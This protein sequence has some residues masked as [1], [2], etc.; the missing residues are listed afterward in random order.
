MSETESLSS[1]IRLETR[2][3]LRSPGRL[4]GARRITAVPRA[5]GSRGPPRGRV[6]GAVDASSNEEKRPALRDDPIERVLSLPPSSIELLSSSGFLRGVDRPRIQT[7]YVGEGLK[8]LLKEGG[9][10]LIFS[11]GPPDSTHM[12]GLRLA[13]D[14]GLPWVADFRDP[15]FNLHMKKPP[16][17]LH[18]VLHRRMEAMVLA[19]AEPVTV[20]EGWRRFLEE[21]RGLPVHLIRNCFDPTDF[22][23]RAPKKSD[24]VLFLLHTGTLSLYRS[25]LAFLE[26][27]ARLLKLRPELRSKLRIDFFGPRES[28]NDKALRQAG[29]SDVV[30]LRGPVSH[31]E[32]LSLQCSADL[33][34]LLQ[35]SDPRYADLVPGKLYEYMGARRPV[36][37][38]GHGQEVSSLLQKHRLGWMSKPAPEVVAATLDEAINLIRT[39][40]QR[41]ETD[42]SQYHCPRQAA[43]MADVFDSLVKDGNDLRRGGERPDANVTFISQFDGR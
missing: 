27:L 31:Q 23:K 38:V 4:L 1:G 36:F 14:S 25:S 40:W 30:R 28:E 26:G 11:S 29:L 20:T 32:A 43:R 9:F 17:V 37:A 21:R 10:D 6:D 3:S 33:L 24:D 34:L 15:W 35:H 18:R 2:S 5:E 16:T 7:S 41:A 39:G 12:V 22:E 8:G 13:R 19:E 42:L